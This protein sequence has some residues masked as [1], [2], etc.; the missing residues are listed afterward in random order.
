MTQAEIDDVMGNTLSMDVTQSILDAISSVGDGGKVVFLPGGCKVTAPII[1]ENKRGI[2]LEGASGQYQYSGSRIVAS[3]TGKAVLSLV[4]SL[5]C[6]V[7]GIGLEGATASRP[8]TGLLL[9]RSSAASAGYHVFDQMNIQGFYSVA[10][11]YNVASEVNNFHNCYILPS[12]A[13]DAG[14]YISGT[15]GLSIG[16]LTGSSCEANTFVGGGIGNADNTSG[17]TGLYLDCGKATGHHQFFGTFMAKNGGDSYILIRLGVVD[18]QSTIFPISFYNVVGEKITTGPAY[19]LHILNGTA[20]A[21]SL[22]GLTV[23]NGRFEDITSNHIAVTGG[24]T[25]ALNGA[26]ISTPWT[27][28]PVRPSTFSALEGSHLSMLYES[29]VDASSVVTGCDVVYGGVWYAPYAGGGNFI[30]AFDGTALSLS[31][32]TTGLVQK[33][34]A[35]VYG[36]TVNIDASLGNQF[37]I[38]VTNGTAFT[39]ANPANAKQGQE[40]S[41]SIRNGSGGATGTVTWDTLYK[42]GSWVAPANGYNRTV[43]FFFNGANWTEKARTPADVPN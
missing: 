21:L 29:E 11:L 43:T 42:Y 38:A 6:R 9:G 31:P 30:R 34:I 13:A 27:S 26:D 20:G 22:A 2:T 18:G 10:G 25:T 17:S 1:A 24:T 3:H 12:S 14:A 32:F 4:G 23:K 41:I 36:A 40:I 33:Q 19:G 8:K 15:D 37:V 5:F 35:P 16:G 39:I 28:S 7:Q